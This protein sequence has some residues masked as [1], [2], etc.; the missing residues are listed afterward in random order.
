MN[1]AERE[2][3]EQ[4]FVGEDEWDE[5]RATKRSAEAKAISLER[6]VE[7]Y[8]QQL[9]Q[10]S[11]LYS[12]QSA[13]A[14]SDKLSAATANEKMNDMQLQLSRKDEELAKM[15]KRNE[16][17]VTLVR[18]TQKTADE[19]E[20]ALTKASKAKAELERLKKKLPRRQVTASSVGIQTDEVVVVVASVGTQADDVV[21]AVE[22]VGTQADDGAVQ[23]LN[24]TIE[25]E[26]QVRVATIDQLN[27]LNASLQE[28][29]QARMATIHEF[30]FLSTTLQEERQAHMAT[31]NELNF[32]NTILQE[33]RQ[34][35][36]AAS[37]ELNFLHTTLQEERQAHL[38]TST[39]LAFEREARAMVTNELRAREA[40]VIAANEAAISASQQQ[41]SGQATDVGQIDHA[42]IPV[43]APSSDPP[44]VDVEM[45]EDPDQP[46]EDVLIYGDYVEAPSQ[47]PELPLSTILYGP[48]DSLP[49]V[50]EDRDDKDE[51]EERL[52]FEIIDPADSQASELPEKGKEPETSALSQPSPPRALN[53]P[54]F[55]PHLMS[56]N[57]WK[58]PQE[59]KG[60]TSM[61]YYVPV[62]PSA[63]RPSP[64]LTSSQPA[65]PLCTPT[66]AMYDPRSTPSHT[67]VQGPSTPSF[68]PNLLLRTAQTPQRPP[69][70]PP[71]QEPET[72]AERAEKIRRKKEIDER[73]R[74]AGVEFDVDSDES[75]ED[76]TREEKIERKR[77]ERSAKKKLAEA[78]EEAADIET[79]LSNLFGEG[80]SSGL[81]VAAPV[82]S[83]KIAPMRN[84]RRE[85]PLRDIRSG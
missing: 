74:R 24:A 82:G 19:A 33:E 53:R 64:F 81:S 66:H 65:A 46:W 10:V 68:M 26:R 79:G 42:S 9:R 75:D 1:H 67:L 31:S 4:K 45:N 2:L 47:Q 18:K 15:Q 16:V 21:V 60:H 36:M 83:R 54:V 84:P 12:E 50:Q 17:L 28:E 40:M 58:M 34:A 80:S 6:Q 76:E 59:E 23:K 72:D 25:E 73:M 14:K 32:L 55:D 3:E 30:N 57:E 44:V 39:D 85:T 22:S 48:Q 5:L 49:A 52:S 62:P 13:G 77:K 56:L 71:P 11:Q 70:P 20:E 35:R 61:P 51:D 78:A 69:P 8:E 7:L 37:N 43:T 63:S 27:L 41:I 38:A 29:R